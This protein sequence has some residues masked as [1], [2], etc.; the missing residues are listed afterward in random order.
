MFEKNDK[1]LLTIRTVIDV[2]TILFFVIGIICSIILLVNREIFPGV[3]LLVFV[4]LCCWLMWLA[5]RLMM[6]FL[7]DVKLIRNKLYGI[8]NENLKVFLEEDDILVLLY[9]LYAQGILTEEEYLTKKGELLDGNAEEFGKKIKQSYKEWI[10]FKKMA[11]K[12]Y[13]TQEDFER[14]KKDFLE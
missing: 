3:F 2:I 11:D 9:N 10:K 6:T 12:G 14:A 7:C 13:I 5:W 4:P 8:G 1:Q